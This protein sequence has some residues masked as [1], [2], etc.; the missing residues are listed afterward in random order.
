ML[1]AKQS[2]DQLSINSRESKDELVESTIDLAAVHS[3][4]TV[5]ND[6]EYAGEFIQTR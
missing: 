6:R 4:K 2:T 5:D 3:K 1:F